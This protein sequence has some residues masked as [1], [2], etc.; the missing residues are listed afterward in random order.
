[1]RYLI[2]ALGLMTLLSGVHPGNYGLVDGRLPTLDHQYS[3]KRLTV[4]LFRNQGFF[5]VDTLIANIY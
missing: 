5:L 2:A 1:M 3:D 4:M